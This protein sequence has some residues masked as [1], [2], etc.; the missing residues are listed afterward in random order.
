[1]E[2]G[3]VTFHPLIERAYGNVESLIPELWD[4]D[5]PEAISLLTL[6][7]KIFYITNQLQIAAPFRDINRMQLWMSLIKKIIDKQITGE[8]DLPLD[9]WD[10]ILERDK[11]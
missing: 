11:T 8:I 5:S 2:K 9:N 4:H 1:M 7:L 3:R 10:A 6:I